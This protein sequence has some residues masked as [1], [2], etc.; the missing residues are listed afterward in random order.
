MNMR[1]LL[2]STIG[3]NTRKARIEPVV[4]VFEKE[5]ATKASTVEQIDRTQARTIIT[6]TEMTGPVPRAKRVDWG[7]RVCIPAANKEPTIK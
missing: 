1:E 2:I 5:R 6:T 4:K 7:I 3:P